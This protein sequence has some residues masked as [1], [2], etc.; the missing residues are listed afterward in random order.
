MA[1]AL[2]AHLFLSIH[3]IHV[4]RILK[5]VKSAE[6][7]RV[8]PRVGAGDRVVI[9]S[10]SPDCKVVAIATVERLVVARP[11]ILWRQ[12]G[13]SSGANEREFLTYLSGV[14]LG[15]AIV[16]ASVRRLSRPI[17]LTSLEGACAGFRPPQSYRYLREDR[18]SDRR[19]LK[20]LGAGGS[21]AGPRR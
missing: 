6:I 2:I 4:A 13:S 3:P 11:K 20:L 17:A 10:T 7:R 8:R 16:F 18:D 19:V 9:Y 14:E 12:V 1:D 21:S 5:G 15:Y